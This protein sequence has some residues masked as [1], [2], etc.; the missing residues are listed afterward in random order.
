MAVENY[1]STG[2]LY[3]LWKIFTKKEHRLYGNENDFT[4]AYLQNNNPRHIDSQLTTNYAI[5]CYF[6]HSPFFDINHST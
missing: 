3:E 6:V 1:K 4:H 5:F 2:T